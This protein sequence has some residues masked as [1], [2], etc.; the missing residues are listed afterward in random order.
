MS[1]GLY[2]IPGENV[3]KRRHSIINSNKLKKMADNEKY[4]IPIG[5]DS[6]P[7]IKGLDEIIG[8]LEATQGAATDAGK[9][10]EGSLKE[11]AAEADRMSKALEKVN[12]KLEETRAEGV[13][14]G[15]DLANA[16][17]SKDGLSAFEK[18][19]NG[20][21][22]KLNE[23]GK[24]KLGIDVDSSKLDILNSALAETSGEINE[25]MAA[26]QQVESVMQQLDPNSEE[27]LQL[28]QAVEYTKAVFETFDTEVTAINAGMNSLDATFEEVY[29]DLQPLN[30]RLRELED[31]MYELALAGGQNTE[32]FRQL[33]RE[34]IKYRQTIQQVDA[35]VDTFAKRSAILDIT[36][37]AAQG[38]TGAFAAA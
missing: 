28:A 19:M 10:L 8:K 32:E 30:T 14:M 9:A 16:L 29:G 7:T 23:I 26:L 4:I 2:L 22:K 35:A 5:L 33:Q 20:F 21:K 25:V 12:Q 34:A 18:T 37:E 24:S 6:N 36:V 11:P 38:L 13:A 1:T 27:F 31:R 15:K 3:K 17:A